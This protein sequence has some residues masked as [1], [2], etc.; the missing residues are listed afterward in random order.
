MSDPPA[1]TDNF[2]VNFPGFSIQG[3]RVGVVPEPQTV[4]LGLLGCA[5]VLWLP[6]RPAR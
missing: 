5:A 2:M 1:V 3:Y 6:R 4:V